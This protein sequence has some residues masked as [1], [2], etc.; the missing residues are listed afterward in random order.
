M[1][2]QN[3]NYLVDHG[4]YIEKNIK[5]LYN[6]RGPNDRMKLHSLQKFD[7]DQKAS[8]FDKMVEKNK[9]DYKNA[10]IYDYSESYGD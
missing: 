2:I 6:N 5:S 9:E 10:Y 7:T 8:G 3:F 1:Y 4:G